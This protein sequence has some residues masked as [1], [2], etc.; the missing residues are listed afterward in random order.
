MDIYILLYIYIYMDLFAIFFIDST[1]E[2]LY[3]AITAIVIT[4]GVVIGIVANTVAFVRFEAAAGVVLYLKI[5]IHTLANFTVLLGNF[6]STTISCTNKSFCSHAF[7]H[8]SNAKMHQHGLAP[9][10]VRR[11]STQLPNGPPSYWQPQLLLTSSQLPS[12]L[13]DGRPHEPA[14][15]SD[16]DGVDEHAQ[17]WQLQP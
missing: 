13:Y 4:A 12:P 2:T 14:H 5:G 3:A 10:V 7:E 11:Q 6:R 8:K 15:S 1:T 9:H 16:D 17:P